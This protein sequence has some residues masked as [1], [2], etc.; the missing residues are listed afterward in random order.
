MIRLHSTVP[1]Q[2]LNARPIRKDDIELFRKLCSDPEVR[3]NTWLQLP[4]RVDTDILLHYCFKSGIIRYIIESSD[5]VPIGTFSYHRVSNVHAAGGLFL[6][7]E[8]RGKGYGK[9]AFAIRDKI[10]KENGIRFLR[11]EIFQDNIPSVQNN[12]R[13]GS[14]EFGWWSKRLQLNA[15]ERMQAKYLSTSTPIGRLEITPFCSEDLPFYREMFTEPDVQFQTYSEYDLATCPD[16]DAIRFLMANSERRW[17][18][19]LNTASKK[20]PVG[21]CHI[22]ET[23]RPVSNFGILLHTPWRNKKLGQALL[24][25]LERAAIEHDI[26]IL[27]ADVFLEST[28][29]IKV[30]EKSGFRQLG[31]Y[32]KFIA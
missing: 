26:R 17:T 8:F 13:S 4:E 27:R 32:E 23:H 24:Q 2:S 7:A 19:W 29:A 31:F 18:A 9:A 15:E 1:F 11:N 20:V 12:L 25:L 5:N 10:L 14:R 30:M 28:P 16:E 6:L 3:K 21:T 22:Y